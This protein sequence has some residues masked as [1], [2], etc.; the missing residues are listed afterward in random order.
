MH[1]KVL[2]EQLIYNNMST[3]RMIGNRNNI[4]FIYYSTLA[5]AV[6]GAKHQLQS[7]WSAKPFRLTITVYYCYNY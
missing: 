1:S 4:I 5:T 7:F 2:C 3:N 6:S